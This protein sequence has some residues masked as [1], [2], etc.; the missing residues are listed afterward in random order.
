[1]ITINSSN[2]KKVFF[3]IWIG[4]LFS[5]TGSGLVQFALVWW[6]TRTTGSAVVL[7]TATFVAL[8]PEVF[9]GPFAGALVDRWNRRLTMI[10]ADS[11]IALATIFLAVLFWTGVVQPWHVFGILFLRAV[12]GVFHWPAMQAST[13][14]IVPDEHL[15]RISGMNQTVRG[16][17]NIFTPALGALLMGLLPLYWVLSVDVITAAIAVLPLLF[18][19]IPQPERADAAEVVTPRVLWRDVRAGF[20]YVAS[21]PGLLMLVLMATLINFVL[22]PTNTLIPLLVTQ[23]FNGGVWHL[24]VLESV[25]GGGVVLGGLVLSVW[26][27][28][29][30]RMLTVMLGVA[31]IGAGCLLVGIAPAS[32]FTLALVG[33]AI[34]GF[35]SPICNGTLNAIMMAKVAKNMQGRVFTLTGAMSSAMIPLSMVI[36]APVAQWLG[37]QVWYWVGGGLVVLMG[38]GG[39]LIP[40]IMNLEDTQPPAAAVSEAPEGIILFI[41]K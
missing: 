5:L 23:H 4:Q 24:G 10:F 3:P 21:W 11:A 26:G 22:A 20:S 15:G 9:I 6:L 16:I 27:G 1:M 37:L 7:A 40:S 12:G 17:L 38:L 34:S 30:K 41:A 35:M 28:F 33:M 18:V 36:V 29:H 32:A 2:W 25:G 39:L 8:L 13:A 19:L 14:M 31:G